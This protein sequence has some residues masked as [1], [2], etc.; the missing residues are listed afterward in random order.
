MAVKKETPDEAVK[1]PKEKILRAAVFADRRDALGVVIQDGEEIT[2]EE[3]QARLD[4]F[5]KAKVN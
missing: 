3:A 1:F 4:K 2:I 5:M